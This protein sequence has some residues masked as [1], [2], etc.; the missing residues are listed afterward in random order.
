MWIR[1]LFALSLS[2]SLL[3]SSNVAAN[4]CTLSNPATNIQVPSSYRVVTRVYFSQCQNPVAVTFQWENYIRG[5]VSFVSPEHSRA[6]PIPWQHGMPALVTLSSIE[7]TSYYYNMHA[8]ISSA[9]SR[10]RLNP[11]VTIS[12]PR[13]EDF[14]NLESYPAGTY[15]TSITLSELPQ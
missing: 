9:L 5:F 3:I 12:M 4:Q 14:V 2:S 6:I 15:H 13:L 10:E 11:I 1:Y 8:T 7:S